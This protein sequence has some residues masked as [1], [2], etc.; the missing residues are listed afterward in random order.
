V[1]TP[2]AAATYAWEPG[3]T[4]AK[5]AHTATFTAHRDEAADASTIDSSTTTAAYDA[6]ADPD[7]C[8]AVCGAMHTAAISCASALSISD[9]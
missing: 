7:H 8:S 2:Y 6:S 9:F 5:G 1:A 4:S 3:N